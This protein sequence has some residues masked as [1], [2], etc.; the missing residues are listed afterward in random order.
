MGPT[1]GIMFIDTIVTRRLSLCSNKVLVGG[2]L[3]FLKIPPRYKDGIVVLAALNEASFSEVYEALKKAPSAL[4]TS[5]DLIAN[6]ESE[7][8]TLS[9]T[10]TRKLITALTSLLRVREKADVPAETFA[11]ELYLVVEKENVSLGPNETA[12]IFKSRLVQFLSLPSLNVVATKAK[13]LLYEVERALCEARILT[14]LRPV[15]GSDVSA[16]PMAMMVVYTLKLS[17]HEGPKGEI[18]EMFMALDADDIAKLKRM[19]ERAETKTAGLASYLQQ[20]G[21]KSPDLK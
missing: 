5:A 19:L 9:S 15:F 18:K 20:A 13:E 10:D 16:R 7:V 1:S 6:I 4:A 21:I 14:D 3:A 11:D 17:Y 8:K 12:D 2:R